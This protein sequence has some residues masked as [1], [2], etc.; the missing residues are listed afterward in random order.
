MPHAFR[1][2]GAALSESAHWDEVMHGGI[3]WALSRPKATGKFEI[4]EK[5]APEMSSS[6]SC[7]NVISSFMGD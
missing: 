3:K 5:W 2:Y 4:K 6:G 7:W 1:R